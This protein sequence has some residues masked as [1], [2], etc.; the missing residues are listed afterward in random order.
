MRR[1]AT[2]LGTRIFS[3][4]ASSLAAMVSGSISAR[5]VED[6]GH[7]TLLLL[8]L[9]V[10]ATGLGVVRGR[11]GGNRQRVRRGFNG[12]L[13]GLQPGHGDLHHVRVAVDGL[14]HIGG[15]P[16]GRQRRIAQGILQKLLH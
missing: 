4:P 1:A 3:I 8:A 15:Q 16:R 9:E 12:N 13:A 10:F 2:A 5:E 6:A 14:I 7:G 11:S